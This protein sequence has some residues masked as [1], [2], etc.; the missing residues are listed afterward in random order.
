LTGR[1]HSSI[2]RAGLEPFLEPYVFIEEKKK[3]APTPRPWPSDQSHRAPAWL[4]CH[5]D[6]RPLTV[7][8]TVAYAPCRRT[9]ASKTKETFIYSLTLAASDPALGHHPKLANDWNDATDVQMFQRLPAHNDHHTYADDG[10]LTTSVSPLPMK[11]GSDATLKSSDG[12][13]RCPTV[14]ING[15]AEITEGSVF[16]L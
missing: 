1:R 2:K 13:K 11:D 14:T 10:H 7:A 12:A 5:S 16:K 6:P 15:R 8:N 3:P 9:S 4:Y